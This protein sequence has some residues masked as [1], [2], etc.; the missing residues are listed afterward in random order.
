MKKTIG[1]VIVSVVAVMALVGVVSAQDQGQQPTT[2]DRPGLD[3]RFPRLNAGVQLL[4][5]LAQ[6]VADDLGIERA[7]LVEQ[8][9]GQTLADL[10]AANGGD[11]DQITADVTAAVTD[12]VNQAVADGNLPQE[13]ADQILANLDET[14]QSAL[15][16]TLRDGMGRPGLGSRLPLGQRPF[17]QNDRRLL[18]NAALDATGLTG[19]ELVQAMRD[20]K[21]LSD[22]ITENGGSP[23]AV[24]ASAIAQ[25]KATLDPA[26][27]N[28]RLTQEQEDAML[29]GLEAF[30]NAVMGGAFRPEASAAV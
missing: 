5:D 10:I 12:R 4:G 24:V 1:L 20:G 26:V 15:N 29:N 22:V 6:I 9:R 25:V 14:V 8:L 28:G 30:Y 11:V 17:L 7:D 21:T 2:P 19:Q 23:D 3:G 16:G 27:A 18:I 13:R